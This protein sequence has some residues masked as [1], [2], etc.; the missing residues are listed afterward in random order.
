MGKEPVDRCAYV[1]PSTLS[2]LSASGREALAITIRGTC[3]C[4]AFVD[5]IFLC[6][7]R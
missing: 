7:P 4:A 2:Y 1:I 3:D 5:V 6:F